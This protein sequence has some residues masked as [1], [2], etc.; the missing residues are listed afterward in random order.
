M[1]FKFVQD[2]IFWKIHISSPLQVRPMLHLNIHALIIFL[3][4]LLTESVII[5]VL[6]GNIVLVK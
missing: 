2:L 4:L 5:N 3:Y 1:S 6:Q